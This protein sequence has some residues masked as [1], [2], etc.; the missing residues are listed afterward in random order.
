MFSGFS[1]FRQ[2]GLLQVI[3]PVFQLF[4]DGEGTFQPEQLPGLFPFRFREGKILFKPAFPQDLGHPLAHA[5]PAPALKGGLYDPFHAQIRKD[6][7]DIGEKERVGGQNHHVFRPERFLEGI[8]EVSNPV[9]RDGGFPASRRAL[10]QQVGG[11][12]MADDD[13]LLRLDRCDDFLQAV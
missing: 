13:V 5:I 8:E 2:Y 10:H 9:K 12:G 1:V 3:Q 6:L 7:G 4:H 11:E